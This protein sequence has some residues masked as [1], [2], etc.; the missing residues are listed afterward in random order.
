MQIVSTQMH[1]SLLFLAVSFMLL[2]GACSPKAQKGRARPSKAPTR[3]GSRARTKGHVPRGSTASVQ[4]DTGRRKLREGRDH[5]IESQSAELGVLSF[6][7]EDSRNHRR[8]M[9]PRRLGDRSKRTSLLVP[10]GGEV[11][12]PDPYEPERLEMTASSFAVRFGRSISNTFRARA[13]GENGFCRNDEVQV[14]KRR[15]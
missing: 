9:E 2:L 7:R 15:G 10:S 13:L 11:L 1:K 6:R 14:P 3:R 8:D 5:W 12:C 4:P